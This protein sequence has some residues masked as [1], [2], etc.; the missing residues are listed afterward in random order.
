MF[1]FFSGLLLLQ[2]KIQ[3]VEHILFCLQDGQ[4]EAASG[5]KRMKNTIS[6]YLYLAFYLLILKQKD[7]SGMFLYTTSEKN[8]FTIP[9]KAYQL[10][11]KRYG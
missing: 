8:L 5:Q 11:L 10:N 1:R 2:V 7:F 3:N 9:F 4:F 6:W